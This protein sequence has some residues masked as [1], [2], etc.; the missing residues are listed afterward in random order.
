MLPA[1]LAEQIEPADKVLKMRSTP[2][3]HLLESRNSVDSKERKGVH[4]GFYRL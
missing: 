4:T 3:F 2:G 1:R